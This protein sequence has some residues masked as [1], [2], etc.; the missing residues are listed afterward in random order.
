[1][2]SV[3]DGEKA[4]DASQDARVQIVTNL[5]TGLVMRSDDP[6]LTAMQL[7]QVDDGFAQTDEE[8]QIRTMLADLGPAAREEVMAALVNSATE[9]AT[10]QAARLTREREAANTLY[11]DMYNDAFDLNL[12]LDELYQMRNRLEQWTGF[13][14]ER[15]QQLRDHIAQRAAGDTRFANVDISSSIVSIQDKLSTQTLTAAD[16]AMHQG[17]LTQATYEKFRGAIRTQSQDGFTRANDLIMREF[18][19]E[20]YKQ[21]NTDDPLV[22]ASQAAAQNAQA[23]MLRWLQANLNATPAEAFA[24]AEKLIKE[25]RLG[26]RVTIL[27]ARQDYIASVQS[28]LGGAFTTDDPVAELEARFALPTDDPK[29]VAKTQSTLMH[30]QVLRD[31]AEQLG[32]D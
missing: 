24:Q 21:A 22:R 3:Y 26:F 25:E 30:L 20:K 5:A 4:A 27:Q 29:Y 19:Y 8:A 32:D 7:Q 17:K 10:D 23:E 2:E 31:Y 9:R 6:E 16:L 13:T 12:P 14:R 28:I 18:R 15:R 1:M 11:S